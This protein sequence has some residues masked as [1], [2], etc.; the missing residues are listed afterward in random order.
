MKILVFGGG[1]QVSNA[2]TVTSPHGWDI[3]T[4]SHQETDI[5]QRRETASVI[6]V[7]RPDIVINAAA[8]TAVDNAE[9]EEQL[10]YLINSKAVGYLVD[11]CAAMQIPLVHFS[12]DFVFDGSQSFPYDPEATTAPLN[13]YGSSKRA[14]E[15]LVLDTA[16]NLVIRTAWV[17]GND[18]KN[19]VKTM[20]KL[21]AERSAVS[22]VDDQIGTP[23]HAKSLATATWALIAQKATGLHHFTD[24]GVA[25][26]FDFAVAIQE[27]A[28]SLGLL[29]NMATIIPISSAQ[30]PMRA[31]R[32]NYSVLDKSE[33]WRLLGNPARH[34]RAELRDM[35]NNFERPI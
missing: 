9:L 28:F 24:A 4:K 21:F 11:I 32:P 30:F 5:T 35:L 22:V 8:Y 27:E 14:G 6:E 17:Y 1:G 29:T 16:D 12:T 19:F 10:A 26:W 34:W 13:V 20:L 2:L 3:V 33:T 15:I 23:T 7:E 18:G 25:S 31:R